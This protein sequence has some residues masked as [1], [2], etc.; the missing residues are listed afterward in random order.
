MGADLFFLRPPPRRLCSTAQTAAPPRARRGPREGLCR[1][2]TGGQAGGRAAH[3]AG[4]TLGGGGSSGSPGALWEG[5]GLRGSLGPAPGRTWNPG[6]RTAA[7]GPGDPSALAPEEARNQRLALAGASDGANASRTETC[8]PR[9]EQPAG[10]SLGRWPPPPRLRGHGEARLRQPNAATDG[11]NPAETRR[12][13]APRRTGSS[14]WAGPGLGTPPASL[15]GRGSKRTTHRP[16]RS[17]D[18]PPGD[19]RAGP[20]FIGNRVLPACTAPGTGVFP[21]VSGPGHW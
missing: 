15:S 16:W 10:Q 13:A 17:R 20:G 11:R 9:S 5:S 14:C 21:P 4:R 2:D 8:P 19:T 3:P 6:R 12:C 1:G 18:P 7:R